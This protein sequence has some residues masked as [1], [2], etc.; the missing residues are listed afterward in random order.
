MSLPAAA[1]DT[2]GTSNDKLDDLAR[3]ALRLG[4]EIV[5]VSGTLD[6]I[7]EDSRAQ[8][9]ALVQL[10]QGAK[11][12][13]DAN[14]SVE[15]M[16]HDVHERAEN[17]QTSLQGL[18]DHL[19]A[20]TTATSDLSTWVSE[21][22]G[23]VEEVVEMLRDVQKSNDLIGSIAGQVNILAINAKIEAA[24]AGT[25][26]L[27][28][29]VVAEEVNALSKK[30]ADAAQSISSQVRNLDGWITS[31]T[32]DTKTYGSLANSVSEGAAT[33]DDVVAEVR[34]RITETER[35][36]REIVT[37][38]SAVR[39]A[40]D[41]FGPAFAR[42]GDSADVT[43]ERI[44]ATR[45]RLHGLIDLSEYMVQGTVAIG[46]VADDAPFIERVTDDANTLGALLEEAAQAGRISEADLFNQSYRPI[47]GTDPEQLLAPYTELTDALF[48]PIQEAALDF[49]DRVVFCAAVDRNGYLPTHNLKFSNPQ[50]SDPIWNAANCRNRRIF[51]DRVGLKSGRNT[52]PF[53]LQVYRRDMGGGEFVMMKDLS[54]PIMVG[55]K[56]WGG[57]R[58]AYNF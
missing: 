7:D 29:A 56:H 34:D 33:T 6:A 42:I 12:L 44:V 53:L 2:T 38:A 27:G 43:G 35:D 51:D 45:D 52:Q 54:A 55:G 21:L 26:G 37:K 39:A 50:G 49:D 22:A 23:R 36:A 46:G 17:S 20:T 9:E 1:I 28:F 25:A 5:E 48:T 8:N 41:G 32:D 47:S 58:L 40:G 18:V 14:Q 4:H 30:T 15:A 3:R 16:A 57:L 19:A 10:R 24:R 13:L 11:E 31:L